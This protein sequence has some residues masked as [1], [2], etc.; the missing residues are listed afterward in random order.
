M[1]KLIGKLSALKPRKVLVA[2]DLMLD[3]YTIGKARR[4]SP[5]APVPVIHVERE[6]HRP[7]GAGN[8]ILNLVS[9]GMQVS[10]LGRIGVDRAGMILKEVLESEGVSLSGLI[11]E[12]M[13]RTPLKNRVIADHQQ[14][15]R[16]DHETV[17]PLSESAEDE[18]IQRIPGLLQDVNVVAISDYGKGFL[19]KKILSVLIAEAKKQLI[20]VIT[21]P[22]GVDF[23]KYRGT[24]ILKPNSSEAYAAANLGTDAPLEEVAQ[25]IIEK[26][27]CDYLMITRSEAGISVFK[28]TVREDF[29]V[30]IKEINDVTGAGDT[31]LAMVTAAIANDLSMQDAAQF[32]NVAAGIAIEH[33]GCARVD[34]PQ[35]AAR[36]LE[37]D[38]ANKVFDAE[39]Q[40]ALDLALD[41][42]K[43]TTIELTEPVF[44]METY[45]RL[46]SVKTEHPL[47]VKV[48]HA[49]HDFLRMLT[50]FKEVDFVV[51]T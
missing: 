46:L 25:R 31:V 11:E 49:N 37:L 24:T 16:V 28:N 6:E 29:P 22:K 14:I 35:L 1:V 9:L 4:I 44:S 2:G 8:A 41:G 27:Q 7:G 5:E 40:F 23:D 32:A 10:V 48:S 12:S 36:L 17:A 51:L 20:P 34:V 47:V 21:D 42:K 3:T 26:A 13:F 39:H 50:S 38:G 18:L 30:R 33:I 43:F 45:Q 19:T 15:V